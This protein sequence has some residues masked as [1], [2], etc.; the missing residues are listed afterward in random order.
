MELREALKN[1]KIDGGIFKKLDSLD[2]PWKLEVEPE[3]LDR[4][5]MLRSGRKSVG[6]LVEDLLDD[7]SEETLSDSDKTLIANLL[8]AEYN[9]NWKK[10][11][12]TLK[13]EYNPIWNK[14][15]TI[16]ETVEREVEMNGTNQESSSNQSTSSGTG[17]K[18]TEDNL[19]IDTEKS[20]NGSDTGTDTVVVDGSVS[21]TQ[22]GT[23]ETSSS[24]S[25]SQS[26]D[27]YDNVFG[28]NSTTAVRN[29]SNTQTNT[30]QNSNT[31]TRTPNLA[32]STDTDQT[33]TETR[34][35]S[36]SSTETNSGTNEREISESSTTSGSSTSSGSKNGS[37][38][39]K[40][41]DN[42][43]SVRLEQ[44]NIG[45]T[46][47]QKLINEE[48]SLWDF[49]FFERIFKDIDEKLVLKIY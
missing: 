27:G 9:L 4:L 33:T 10:L 2:V 39:Q 46:S 38:H 17:S 18:S 32:S 35:L 42:M 41:D 24:S 11:Y 25:G 13:F 19:T 12:A 16:T 48:R 29:T 43:T 31:S 15:E 28:F 47:T 20:V 37:D 49:N 44:G 45:L 22:T 3:K 23:E 14:N 26:V 34:D 1:W 21:G 8:F 5:Y 30:D 7:S 6:L 36:S 40:T